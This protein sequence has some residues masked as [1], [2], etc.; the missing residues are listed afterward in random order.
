MDFKAPENILELIKFQ[1]QL[2]RKYWHYMNNLVKER[3]KNAALLTYWLRDYLRYLQAEDNF[4]PRYNITYKRGQIVYVNFGYR[5]GSELG[6][7]HYAIVLDVKNSKNNSQ[8]T[9][10]PMKSK[11]VKETSYTKI[12]HVDLYGEVRTLLI[13]KA[14]SMEKAPKEKLQEMIQEHG[15]AGIKEDKTLQK[16]AANIK[17]QIVQ[18]KNI[19]DFAQ[20][21]LN[22][23]SIAD[24]GQICTISKM[25][26]VHPTKKNDVLAGVCL[27]DE[28]LARIETKIKDLFFAEIS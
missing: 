5:I 21:K 27:S 14:A 13:D 8:L 22:H 26:I 12:Y 17:R 1:K 3:Y 6:G 2:V 28:S 15:L 10:I 19:Y 11:R 16:E 4:N 20:N 9:V 23:E 18:A 24:V 25:R 7:C